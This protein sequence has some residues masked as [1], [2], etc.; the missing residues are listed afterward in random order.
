MMTQLLAPP[1]ARAR[2]TLPFLCVGETTTMSGENSGDGGSGVSC[3]P[4]PRRVIGSS[5]LPFSI[6]ERFGNVYW[7]LGREQRVP[8]WVGS[9]RWSDFGGAA[10]PGESPPW[11]AAREF[12]EETCACIPTYT[13][14]TTPT[15]SYIPLAKALQEGE[16][17]FKLLTPVGAD[18]V[19][20]TY[21]MQIP[22]LPE[23]CAQMEHTR[24]ALVR[25]R[26][27]QQQQQPPP[28]LERG[29]FLRRH[30]AVNER[31]EVNIDYLE[32]TNLR[33]W[34]SV[35][36]KRACNHHHGVIQTTRR[37][38]G[39][40]GPSHEQ[41]RSTFRHRMRI[42]LNEFPMEFGGSAATDAFKL[43]AKI[44]YETYNNV[45]SLPTTTWVSAA[46]TLPPLLLR[47]PD[48]A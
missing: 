31:G 32:K 7:L 12:V 34:S 48:S 14:Q 33:F 30:P 27:Q 24:A 47:Q 17:T 16:Y 20:V 41:L 6:D 3:L 29:D 21:A 8:G 1:G 45:T 39:E 9:E 2:A 4:P 15:D 23:T 44:N 46:K 43:T 10:K 40:S 38:S 25:R 37:M 35:Q 5:I 36:L 18:G 28:P 19:Y 22:M 13:G 26:Q 42:V 11:T